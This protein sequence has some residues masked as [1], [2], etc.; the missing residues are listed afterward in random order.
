MLEIVWNVC[1]IDISS[2]KQPQTMFSHF[3]RILNCLMGLSQF[4]DNLG[5]LGLEENW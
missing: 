5:S 1:N 4:Q 2:K 3:I